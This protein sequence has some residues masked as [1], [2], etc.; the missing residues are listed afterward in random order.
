VSRGVIVVG[1]VNHDFTIR[2]PHL[3]RPGETVTGGALTEGLGG[4]GA[5]QAVAAARFG[6]R[7][8]L[9]AAVGRDASGDAALSDLMARGVDVALVRRVAEP[10]GV[11]QI[12]VDHTGEN[13]IAVAS[14]ANVA[15]DP[16]AVR[17][18]IDA[19][20]FDDAVVLACLEIALDSV[21][22]AA[23]AAE[24]RGFHFVLNPAPAFALPADL[25]RRSTVITPNEVELLGLGGG[26]NEADSTARL[27]RLGAD[28]LV[29]THGAAGAIVY[30]RNGVDHVPAPVVDAVDTTG[31]GDAFNA[32]LV[33][34]LSEGVP[35]LEAVRWGVVAG[36]AACEQVGA[37][38]GL[39]DRATL[40]RRLRSETGSRFA[41]RSPS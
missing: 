8:T 5:N 28:A 1:S 33:V 17:R 41:A 6:A 18:A 32:A 19:A 31:A 12:A 30:R 39:I 26:E 22:A 23:M 14:G 24:A 29:V 15:L 7:T 36:A 37:Q 16:A 10:T 13:Q 20:V 21:S 11:A 27:L 34:A 2:L 3:P 35:L 40:E 4:K 38:A 25:V 9:I